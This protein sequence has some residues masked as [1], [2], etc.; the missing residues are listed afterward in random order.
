MLRYL[1][2]AG[3]VGILCGVLWYDLLMMVTAGVFE[4]SVKYT[5]ST[6]RD[7]KV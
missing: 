3:L 1:Y 7:T 6:V 5:V 2:I 4:N